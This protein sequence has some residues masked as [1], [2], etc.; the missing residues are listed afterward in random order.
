VKSR[1]KNYWDL[2]GKIIGLSLIL[3]FAFVM[4][5][6][7][8]KKEDTTPASNSDAPNM[9]ATVS[10]SMY[11]TP[12]A[13]LFSGTATSIQVN[14]GLE[15]IGI[16]WGGTPD[17]KE[18]ALYAEVTAP[19]TYNLNENQIGYD[20]D[21][22]EGPDAT[23]DYS[24]HTDNTHTGTLI[25]TKYDANAKKVSG[26]FSFNATLDFPLTGIA[27]VTNG[28]FTDVGW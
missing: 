25:I 4:Q 23:N 3:N 24:Y 10:G 18:I 17:F 21:Y 16:Q 19:G 27:S 5:S 6:C 13:V 8:N 11:S 1:S 12:T 7:N 15:I 20:G 28:A 2:L 14:G 26:T 22:V 9:T